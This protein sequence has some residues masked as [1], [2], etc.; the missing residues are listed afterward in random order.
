MN[1]LADMEPLAWLLVLAFWFM[2]VALPLI[3]LGMGV[4]IVMRAV[5]PPKS[6]RPKVPVSGWRYVVAIIISP[7]VFLLSALPLVFFGQIF[8]DV[9]SS[10]SYVPFVAEVSLPLAVTIY[11]FQGILRSKVRRPN[12][13]AK[14]YIH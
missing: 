2:M 4:V 8:N 3:A 12:S 10:Q 11:V 9:P 5:S 6:K 14:R 13:Y 1:Y 7:I